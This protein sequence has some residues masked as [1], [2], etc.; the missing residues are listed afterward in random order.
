[1]E[2]AVAPGEPAVETP[3]D[4]VICS[5]GVIGRAPW[6]KR[7]ALDSPASVVAG[8]AIFAFGALAMAVGKVP[9][10]GWVV[11]G[12]WAALTVAAT[13]HLVRIGHRGGCLLGRSLWTGVAWLGLPLRV[14]A[15]IPF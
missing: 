7:D 2:P 12:I 4:G 5:C 8:V 3:D 1:M 14:A 11:L 10:V 13:I 9:V 6:R 15:A